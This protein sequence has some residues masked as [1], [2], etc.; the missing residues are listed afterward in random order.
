MQSSSEPANLSQRPTC[1]CVAWAVT[2]G[3]VEP[4]HREK[5]SHQNLALCLYK[6]G[7]ADPSRPRCA[8]CVAVPSTEMHPGGVNQMHRLAWGATLSPALCTRQSRAQPPPACSCSS[9]CFSPKGWCLHIPQPPHLHR[10]RKTQECSEIT[11][12]KGRHM[13]TMRQH[14]T[15]SVMDPLQRICYSPEFSDA[16]AGE[17][18]LQPLFSLDLA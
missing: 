1:H 6:S 4:W 9:K 7:S 8:Q 12:H 15:I 17:G 18:R 11:W 10:H 5:A 2:T 16:M 3:S 13:L 14:S